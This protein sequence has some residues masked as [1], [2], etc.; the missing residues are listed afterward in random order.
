MRFSSRALL[1]VC[2]LAGFP[3]LILALV[4]G[5]VV[6]EIYA[7]GHS[8]FGAVKL[9]IFTVPA[10]Y[11][12]IRGLFEL[13]RHRANE[14][15]GVL[16]TPETQPELW[17]LV[18]GLAAEVGTRP[19]DDIRLVPA[20]NAAVAEETR[21]L[22]LRAVR[23][24]LYVGAP[25]LAGLNTGELRA[26]LAHELAHYSNQDTRLAGLTYRGERTMRGTLARLDPSD[27]FQRLVRR[28]FVAYAKLYFK[29]SRAVTRRQELAAD[30][31]S[32][33][34]AGP[35][36]AAG[37]LRQIGALDTAWRFFVNNYATIGWQAGFLPRRFAE[38]FGLLLADSTR[39][40]EL[41]RIRAN[42]DEEESPY[43]THPSMAARIAALDGMPPVP[44]TPGDER[45]AREILRDTE[46]V[47]DAAMQAD[48]VEEAKRKQRVDWPTLIDHG[49]R[50]RLATIS[51]G[52]F[53]EA[54]RAL[55]RPAT[56]NTLLDA[57]DAGRFTVLAD[58]DSRAADGAGPRARREFAATSARPRLTTVLQN[59]LAD[60]GH[61]RWT[62][63]WSDSAKLTLTPPFDTELEP[64]MDAAFDGDTAPLRTLLG[65]AEISLAYQPLVPTPA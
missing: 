28:L 43:D 9:A 63:S 34:I 55:G 13:E 31:A 12:L 8:P 36:T 35:A 64:A 16:V 57:V 23:R 48:L 54:E 62:L 49:C 59:A 53:A 56:L 18:R 24:H 20:V 26:V 6:L 15:S 44:A 41:D 29:V 27:W 47:L 38:G 42:P 5:L 14:E 46:A 58:P 51:A 37:A 60:A 40:A 61:A 21:L 39:Q 3:V 33:R 32:G 2:L 65:K 17:A 45:P 11:A 25:L 4:A 1:A 22:G 7:I 50:H 30:A 10:G 19:P 52:I